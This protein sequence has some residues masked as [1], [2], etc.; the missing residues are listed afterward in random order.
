MPVSSDVRLAEKTI[1]KMISEQKFWLHTKDDLLEKTMLLYREKMNELH[2]LFFHAQIFKLESDAVM[3]LVLKER[4]LKS[5]VLWVLKWATEF[6][7]NKKSSKQKIKNKSLEDLI[8][9]G[10]AYEAFVDS[11]KYA[12]KNIVDIKCDVSKR[13]I[14]IFEG[15][16]VTQNDNSIIDQ[17]RLSYPFRTH[18][19]LTDDDVQLTS[20]W[21]A[22]KYRTLIQ[23]L[24]NY[25]HSKEKVIA[26]TEE[27]QSLANMPEVSIQEPRLVWLSL[28]KDKEERMVFN[29]L[30]LP[31]EISGSEKWKLV[32]FSETPIVKIGDSYCALSSDLKMLSISDD[33]MLRSAAR[34]DP[35]Q[36]SLV[37]GLREE[38]MS[39]ICSKALANTKN[40]WSARKGVVFKKPTQEADVL[41]V[42]ESETMVLELKSTLRPETP[43]EVKKR[44]DDLLK[45]IN[46][47]KQFL[48]RKIANVGFVV[49]DGYRGDY[50]CWKESLE[51]GVTIATLDDIEEIALSPIRAAKNIRHKTGM[52]T[53]TVNKTIKND[54][55]PERR[56]MIFAWEIKVVDTLIEEDGEKK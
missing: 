32:S 35:E 1:D 11:L 7:K 40:P 34:I 42:R 6:C 41:A 55:Y 22:G 23:S 47:V 17:G 2:K 50:I 43:W 46:Q 26:I 52:K 4:H 49:T 21:T 24:A 45:G 33:Y 31:T 53:S 48:D 10:N 19:S 13:Q 54:A 5:G 3:E 25:A 27:F 15:G 9:F 14:T 18:T 51:K 20:Q 16:S 39:D 38:K 37:S 36:Y 44:N 30:V 56:S 29:S 28:P 12:E 8:D